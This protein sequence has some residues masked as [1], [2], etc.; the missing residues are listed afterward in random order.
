MKI[1]LGKNALEFFGGG[2][3]EEGY[4]PKRVYEK[5]VYSKP[6]D[7]PKLP[8][9]E[10]IIEPSYLDVFRKD[11]NKDVILP[12]KIK[13]DLDND[14]RLK[15]LSK[16]D[17]LP[18]IYPELEIY[19]KFVHIGQ[20]KLFLSEIQHLSAKLKS[21]DEVA[22]VVYSGA[23]PTNKAWMEHLMFPNVKFLL[24]DPNMFNIYIQTYQDS[25]YLHADEKTNRIV[26]YGNSK[27]NFN[28][29]YSIKQSDCSI[30]YFDGEREIIIPD[31]YSQAAPLDNHVDEVDMR[32]IK[33]FFESDNCIFINEKYFSNNTARFCNELFKYRQNYP[34]YKDCK[35][36]Y[37]SDIRTDSG[38]ERDDYPDDLDILW[39]TAMMYNWVKIA[40]PDYAMLKFR[41]PYLN[42]E[43]INFDRHRADFDLCAKL[44]NDLEKIIKTTKNFSFF[45]GEIYHQAWHGRISTE[46]RLW[47]EGET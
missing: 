40:E 44:G 43:P 16:R 36:F 25:H 1:K 14:P 7:L 26:Y 35:T 29:G 12:P 20:R 28:P 30:K 5:V 45:K 47:I 4:K 6:S 41:T 18:R 46:T 24:V 31:K 27:T 15:Y 32:Y 22:I 11:N 10:K 23:A 17:R 34:K 39:N 3:Y 38:G 9:F 21:K 37:W 33:H 8:F 13:L 19:N 2:V 42:G